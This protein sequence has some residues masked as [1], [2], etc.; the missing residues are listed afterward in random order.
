MAAK[1]SPA[2]K[3]KLRQFLLSLYGPQVNSWVINEKVLALTMK[4]LASQEGCTK[5]M[6]FIPF[7]KSPKK[8]LY[9][10]TIQ[11]LKAFLKYINKEKEM[12][13]L[14]VQR[15]AYNYKSFFIDL[16]RQM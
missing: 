1:L 9:D 11:S 10:L 12:N 13:M 5:Q 7:L 15:A 2:D 8:I 16:Q 4:M 6:R 14:C 3:E